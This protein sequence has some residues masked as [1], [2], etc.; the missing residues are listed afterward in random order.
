MFD[1][2]FVKQ[3][4]LAYHKLGPFAAERERF[5]AHCSELG[6]VEKY[7]K[8]IAGVLLTAASDL[9]FHGGL[10]ADQRRLEAAA[11]RIERARGGAGARPGARAYRREFLRITTR[12]LLFTGHLQDAIASPR[13]Y[14]ALLDDFAR[15]MTEERG[16]SPATLENRRWHVALFLEW[17][18]ARGRRV[19]DMTLL[20]FDAHLKHLHGKGLSRVT[21]KIHTNALR[22]FIHHAERRGWCAVGLAAMLP[23]PRIYREH[24]LP[25]GPSWE[26]VKGLIDSVCSDTA[27][28]RRASRN[29][30]MWSSTNPPLEGAA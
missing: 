10:D 5:L 7:L 26:E 11:T 2:L 1:K 24:G 3:S 20:D 15:W 18:H 12:W 22:A 23:G 25:R 14:A 27:R 4:D 29:A 28:L 8:R 16:L 13:P 17:L 21:I 30:S 9:Q 19:G 6:Y